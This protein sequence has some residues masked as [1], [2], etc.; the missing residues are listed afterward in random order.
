MR[1]PKRMR[2]GLLALSTRQLED[3]TVA[4]YAGRLRIGDVIPSLT[5]SQGFSVMHQGCKKPMFCLNMELALEYLSTM[6]MAGPDK[7]NHVIGTF[8]DFV[9][10]ED[11]DERHSVREV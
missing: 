8:L 10:A 2:K 9:A 1:T 3:G 7:D 6:M 4:V 5:E 11:E